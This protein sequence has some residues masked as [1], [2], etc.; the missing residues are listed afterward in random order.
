MDVSVNYRAL[1]QTPAWPQ[2]SIGE[3]RFLRNNLNDPKHHTRIRVILDRAHY[4]ALAQSKLT[5][6]APTLDVPL[7]QDTLCAVFSASGQ[8][9][10]SG[11]VHFQGGTHEIR[12]MLLCHAGK[13]QPCRDGSAD[14]VHR[15]VE[16]KFSE[17]VS[18]HPNF[19]KFAASS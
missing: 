18:T 1:K 14:P 16:D 10:L 5:L 11:K 7:G 13:W 6:P 2:L 19:L 8:V 12:M 9:T 15:Y 3:K 17:W 4:K